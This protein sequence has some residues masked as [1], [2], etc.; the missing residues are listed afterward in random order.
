LHDHRKISAIVLVGKWDKR[1]VPVSHGCLL[2]LG[3]LFAERKEHRK[4][5]VLCG[6]DG[7]DVSGIYLP[8]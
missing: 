4:P 6:D 2:S 5:A 3:C 1:T 8:L 7:E